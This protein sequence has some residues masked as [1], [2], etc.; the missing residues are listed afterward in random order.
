MMFIFGL[1][2]EFPV[3]LVALELANVITPQ[4][5]LKQWRYALIAIFAAAAILT[6]SGDPISM[7]GMVVPLTFFYFLAILVGKIAKK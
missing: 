4:Q 5:L 3:I 2:F 1:T 6:P 7:F